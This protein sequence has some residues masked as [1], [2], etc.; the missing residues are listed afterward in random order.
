LAVGLSKW[1]NKLRDYRTIF[2]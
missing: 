2:A 1:A